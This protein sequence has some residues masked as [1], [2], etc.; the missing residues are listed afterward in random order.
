MDIETLRKENNLIDLFCTLAQIPSPSGQEDN[1][2]AKIIEILTKAGIKAEHDSFKN[3]I[4][5]VPATDPSKK[6]LAL[7]AHMDV[8]GDNSPVNLR[9]DG[10]FIETDKKRTLGA[11]DK[12][13]VAAAM[14]LAMEIAS[15]KDLKH[16]GLEL[17]FTKDEE[18]GL[19]GINNFDFSQ[20]ESEYVLVIDADKAGQ[21]LVAGAS[22]TNALLTVTTPKGGHSGIDIADKTRANAV[23]LIAELI[24]AIPQGVYK[25]NELGVITSIN[26]GS[27]IG[28]GVEPCIKQISDES[29]KADSYIDYISE[30]SMTNLINTRARARYSIRSSEVSTENELIAKI[31]QIV[32]DFN[33]KYDGIASAEF[34]ATPHL[35]AFERSDDDTIEKVGKE[36]CEKAGITPD[37]SSFHAG[38]ETHVYAKQKNKNGVPFKPYLIGSADVFNMHSPDEKMDA[39]SYLKGYESIK[40]MFLI[41]NS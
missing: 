39:A 30:K 18:Q 20:L 5:K 34:L 31:Q 28:G 7:S 3:V 4:A 25:A 26:I 23:K 11:D 14:K 1:V 16:G 19:S 36:A 17:V 21:I 33:K 40:N 2:S 29:I 27:V 41:F 37:I 12:A 9:Y 22:Y 35:P 15:D 6:P 24:N 8:I 38:A 13:G 32:A 10:K